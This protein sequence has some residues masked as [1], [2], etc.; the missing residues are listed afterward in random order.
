MQRFVWAVLILLA[1]PF[2][3][4]SAEAPDPPPPAAE[5]PS[6]VA[7]TDSEA[8]ERTFTAIDVSAFRDGAHHWRKIRDPRRVIHVLPEQAAYAPD[9]VEEIVANMLLFQRANGG[10]PKDYDMLAVLTPEQRQA[11]RDTHHLLDTSFDNYNIHS[12][13]DYLARG[14]AAGGDQ[15]WRDACLRGFD[16]MLAAQLPG[17]GFPQRYPEPT[18][19][20]RHITFNDGVTVGVLN[21][22]QDAAE[23]APHWQWLDEAR[24]QAAQQAV[25]RGVETILQCQIGG[26]APTG[27]CQQH[28][29]ET[30]AA[31]PARTF[32]LASICP[33]ETTAIVRFLMR[34]PATDQRVARAVEGAV[35]WLRRTQL[36]GIRVERIAAPTESYEFHT[37]DFDVVVVRD[38]QAQP[39]WARHYEIGSDRP[40][41]AGRDAV[42]RYALSE[43]ERE[44]RT[45]TP[46][47]GNWPQG[48][49]AEDYPRWRQSRPETP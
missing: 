26:D 41:F 30:L 9:Q 28:D 23:R 48:L 4:S 19:F 36:D 46:W 40:I 24:R 15:S 33:Q 47:Y 25:Q 29:P 42:K 5:L 44:R 27:W 37:T 2:S 39:L 20:A 3:A 18:G 43:I 21:V 17:G 1:S 13:V 6:A 38:E 14:Y 8:D 49:L 16:F 35:A 45:G 12:Q 11:V 34:L 7:A 31:A 10:W 32:E 22:F